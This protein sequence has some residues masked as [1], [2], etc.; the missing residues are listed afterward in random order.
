V[1]NRIEYATL[2]TFCDTVEIV[3]D[4]FPISTDVEGVRF[5]TVQR[6]VEW[7]NAYYEVE[8]LQGTNLSYDSLSSFVLRFV[9]DGE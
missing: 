4:P 6:D 8:L 3:Y 1:L 2:R 9:L 7:A 5:T